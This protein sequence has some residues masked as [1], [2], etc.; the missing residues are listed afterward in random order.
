MLILDLVHISTLRSGSH[1]PLSVQVAE[2]GPMS[3][4][5][6]GQLKVTVS[7]SIGKSS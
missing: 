2:L 1:S 6:G 5:S 4:S 7:P 3:S